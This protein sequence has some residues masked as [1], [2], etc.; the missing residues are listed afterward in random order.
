MERRREH[1]IIIK[2]MLTSN[3]YEKNFKVLKLAYGKIFQ[4]IRANNI[5]ITSYTYEP[6]RDGFAQNSDLQDAVT[7][8]MENCCIAAESIIHFPEISYRIFGKQSSE[9]KLLLNWCYEFVNSFPL[10]I[11]ESTVKL[12][13]ILFQEI[14]EEL[15]NPDYVNPYY[16]ARK[17]QGRKKENKRHKKFKKGPSLNGGKIEL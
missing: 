13:S 9:W 11:D 12:M 14:N 10:I 5:T 17:H 4:F 8:V 15:R 2:N 1:Q 7:I 16:E 6:L 3:N